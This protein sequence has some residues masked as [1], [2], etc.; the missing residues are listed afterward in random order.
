MLVSFA[1]PLLV[2]NLTGSALNVGLTM[3][4]NFLPYVLFGLVSGVWVDRVNRKVLMIGLDIARTVL[5]GLV[6]ILA[7]SP[8]FPLCGSI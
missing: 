1:L 4:A 5:L 7:F 6:P 2:F 8:Q 3:A